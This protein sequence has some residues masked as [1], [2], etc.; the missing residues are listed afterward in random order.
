M[1]VLGIFV[2]TWPIGLLRACY[3][4]FREFHACWDPE[5]FR[6]NGPISIRRLIANMESDYLTSF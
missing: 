6:N 1:D 2:H 3:L 5:F 4:T